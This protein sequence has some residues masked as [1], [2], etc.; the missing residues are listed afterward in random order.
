MGTVFK[1]QHLSNMYLKSENAFI[2]ISVLITCHNSSPLPDPQQLCD[3]SSYCET[4]YGSN[5][6]SNQDNFRG[7]DPVGSSEDDGFFSQDF[8][9]EQQG[10]RANQQQQQICQGRKCYQNN[11]R[12][13][14]SQTCFGGIC[15]QDN[16]KVGSNQ[17]KPSRRGQFQ[18][19]NG[20]RGQYQVT[21]LNG[22]HQQKCGSGSEC[23]I[24]YYDDY[25]PEFFSSPMEFFYDETNQADTEIQGQ[26]HPGTQQ[27]FQNPVFTGNGGHGQVGTRNGGHAGTQN[28]WQNQAGTGIQGQNQPRT[29][30]RGQQNQAGTQNSSGAN[31]QRQQICKGR[32]CYQNNRGGGSQG[33]QSQTCVGGICRQDNGNGGSNQYKQSERGQFQS[34][35]G[36]RGQYQVTP[37]N[38]GHQQKC[39]GGS[40]CQI[41]YGDNDPDSFSSPMEFSN[42]GANQADP[43]IQGQNHPGTQQSFKNPV[44]TGNGGHNGGH[45][46]VGTRNGG[47]GQVGT[48]NGGYN[49]VGRGYRGQNQAQA[50]NRGH[51]QG[52]YQ[53]KCSN[54]SKCQ[55]NYGD[56]DDK[57]FT[58][59][60][61]S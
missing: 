28:D 37:L 40:E 25:D 51:S 19:G 61:W 50:G 21:P 20:N 2:I 15:R 31:Q 53:Q 7:P 36:N 23:Q 39:V 34:G 24:N 58:D 41:N 49:Q 12:G 16:G 1:F 35:T 22:G 17:Y 47:H 27:S 57:F 33:G 54:G 11:R 48:R 55:V 38:G 10:S 44:F 18:P 42:E 26:N 9:F 3:S 13:Q 14:G 46:Q 60:F 52:G 6:G 30:N 32:K 43:E 45:G 5:S 29:G 56:Y 8:P 4:R 59:D